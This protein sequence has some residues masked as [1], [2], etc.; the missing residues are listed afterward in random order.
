MLSLAG[1]S[2]PRSSHLVRN[3]HHADYVRDRWGRLPSV[4]ANPSGMAALNHCQ[5]GA[6]VTMIR[7]FDQFEAAQA[8]RQAL[9]DAGI[10]ADHVELTIAE[11]EAGPAQ[12]NFVAGDG[13]EDE[14]SK[15]GTNASDGSYEHSYHAVVSRSVCWLMVST[16]AENES[17]V[18]DLLATFDCRD[19]QKA[20]RNAV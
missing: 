16:V 10:D 9:L 7:S 3:W 18:A 19:P 15:P 6:V 4:R 8:A 17:K 14:D 12:G 2:T 11:H 1:S 20:A 5:E 13:R